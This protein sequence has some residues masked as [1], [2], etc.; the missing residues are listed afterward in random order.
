VLLADLR[1]VAS[2]LARKT[3]TGDEYNAHGRFDRGTLIAR[4]GSWNEA[5]KQAGLAVTKR[6]NIPRDELIAD[7]RRV[8]KDL[9]QPTV[10]LTQYK[11]HGTFSVDTVSR[12]F[13]TWRSALAA[14]HLTPTG[15]TQKL[16]DDDLFQNLAHVWQVLARPPTRDEMTQPLSRFG[17]AGYQRRFGSWRSALEGFVEW[18][19]SEPVDSA[20]STDLATRQE[21][22]STN[23][24]GPPSIDDRHKTKRQISERLKVRVLIRDGNRCRLC[25][26]IVTGDEIHFDHIKPWSEG[27]ETTFDNI[28]VLCAKHNLAKGNFYEQK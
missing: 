11:I 12:V 14:A 24:S 2:Q 5:L 17:P 3:L 1:N 13:G 28:Q 19:N 10:T 26:V 23:P 21:L 8:A 27:G 9:Q 25:G 18:V 7:L 16:S 6:L 15:F 20:T 22:S 4:F